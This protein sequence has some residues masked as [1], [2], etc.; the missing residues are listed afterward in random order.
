LPRPNFISISPRR[1]L[2]KLASYRPNDQ[3][4]GVFNT[5][6][7]H[8]ETGQNTPEAVAKH[9]TFA[10]RVCISFL[11]LWSPKLTHALDYG[12]GS[13]VGA[14]EAVAQLSAESEETTQRQ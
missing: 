6:T 12:P 9:A 13:T 10:A 4:N 3:R 8:G 14:S 11:L 5:T 7:A 1:L 2:D